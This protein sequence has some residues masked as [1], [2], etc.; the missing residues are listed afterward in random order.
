MW[1]KPWRPRSTRSRTVAGG[2]CGF[3]F[4]WNFPFLLLA[5]GVAPALAAGNTIVVKPAENS[6]L[7]TVYFARLAE[8]AGVPPG[9]INIIPG[10]GEKAGAALARHPDLKRLS[11][12]G[13]PEVGRLIAAACGQNLVPVKLELGG[14]GAAVVFDDVN[15]DAVAQGLAGAITFNAGQVCCTATR[16]FV[17]EKLFDSFVDKVTT[18]LNAAAIGHG[19]DPATQMGP[20]VSAKQRAR[21]LGYLERGVREGGRLLVPGGPANVPEYPDG[22]YVKPAVMTGP[23][24]NVCARDEVF[25]PFAYL[26]PF[27]DEAAVIEEV[28]RSPYGLANSVWTADLERANRVAEKLVAGTSWINGHNLVAHGI[29]YGGCNQSGCGGG[30]LGPNALADYLRPQTVSRLA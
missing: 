15:V 29:P 19:A 9:V 8:E 7:S 16:W 27:N 26:R 30:V 24:D 14:K 18:A 23:A 28:N 10:F 5:W 1:T 6:P 2:V 22:Y 21:V 4:P 11:F 20:L 25:G 3:I 13:S 12:T 17:H